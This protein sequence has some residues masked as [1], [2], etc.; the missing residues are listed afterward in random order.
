MNKA[1]FKYFLTVLILTL[2]VSTSVSMIILSDQML[3]ATKNDMLYSVKL[4]DYQ[5]DYKT[6]L[7]TQ[8][9]K[10]NEFAYA[11]NSRLTI[12][13]QK[14]Q[15][16][17]DSEQG[18][19]E[20][21]HLNR[22]EVQQALHENVG[23]ATRYSNTLKRNMLYVAYFHQGHIVRLAIPY[24]GIFDNI[25]PLIEPLSVS[26]VL[27]LIVALALSYRFSKTLTQPLTEISEEV[28]KMKD[29][30]YLSFNHYKY[31]E[32]NIIATKLKQQTEIIQETLTTLK[33]ERLKINSI[34][35]QMNEGFILLDQNDC[36]LMCNMKVKQLYTKKMKVNHS[37]RDYIFDYKIIEGLDD[38][39]VEQ[40]IV[41]ITKNEEI[42]RCFIARV[43]YG[44]TLL[45]VNVTESVKAMKM[46]QD[47]FSNVSHE[48]KTPM[49]SI[50]GYSELLQAGMIDNSEM[51]QQALDKIQQEVDHMSQLINDILMI[52]RLENKDVDVIVHPVYLQPIVEELLSSLQMEIKKK[53]LN[54]TYDVEHTPYLS[55]HQHMH[56]LMNNL[57]TNAVKY[58][59]QGGDVSLHCYVSGHDYVIEVSD[60][61]RGISRIDQ[62]RVFERF[63][64][65]DSGRD[66]ETGGTGLGLAIVKHI[67][68]YYQ[69]NIQLTSQLDKG[70][71]FKIVLPIKENVLS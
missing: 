46:R 52:S 65:C 22:E 41:D 49:T 59:K 9:Q 31:D 67:T 21:N 38:L 68:Q 2:L 37:I 5:L 16:L 7:T 29:S 45:F 19:I 57:L 44:V 69:G 63:F 12:I 33:K 18:A 20:E 24:N 48:L 14:G 42:Y 34:L 50:R 70:T 47:F 6:D 13:D 30:Q 58:N 60:T 15:V 53:Q 26:T 62:G 55:N 28:M 71:T 17:G 1:V 64:R 43:D 11:D 56:Q 54:V 8:V 40:K 10:L 66:K 61:G 25:L 4:I 36:I 35:D 39:G 23:Y 3:K 27:S 32:F 51:K